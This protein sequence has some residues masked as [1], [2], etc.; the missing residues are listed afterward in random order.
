MK[1]GFIAGVNSKELLADT[2]GI[3]PTTQIE[4]SFRKAL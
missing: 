4:K 3:L 1:G 2:H